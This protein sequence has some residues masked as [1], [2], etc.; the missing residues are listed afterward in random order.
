MKTKLEAV[1]GHFVGVYFE[2]E[3]GV[4]ANN[5]SDGSNLPVIEVRARRGLKRRLLDI[6]M[7]WRRVHGSK[8]ALACFNQ[9]SP[10]AQR[11]REKVV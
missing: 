9:A 8:E 11:K 7:Q 1:D 3:L 4:K 2:S 6:S 5:R 10:A